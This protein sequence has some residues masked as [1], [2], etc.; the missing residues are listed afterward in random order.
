MKRALLVVL[1]LVSTSQVS[2]AQYGGNASASAMAGS[3]A[4]YRGDNR[5]PAAIERA[6]RQLT[7]AELRDDGTSHFIEASVL[8][9]VKAD[10]YVAVFG[11]VEEGKTV[12]EATTK[13]DA[14]IGKFKQSLKGLG[15][16]DGDIFVDFITQNR[17]YSYKI[18]PAGEGGG[19]TTI[20]EELVGFEIKK[21]VSIHF[22]DKLL[23]DA[24]V[25]AG[26]P[27][28]I[29]D[30]VKVDYVVKDIAAMKSRLQ[31]ETTRI[32][33]EKAQNH[34]AL[35]GIKLPEVSQ[36]VR[37]EPNIYFP[38]E[39][40]DSY[41]AAEAEN[42]T[43][44]R[45]EDRVVRARKNR[46]SYFNPLSGDGFDMVVNPVII[47]PVVQFTTYIKVRY[48]TPKPQPAREIRGFGGS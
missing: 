12:I 22:K 1:S 27:A 33:K 41:T 43:T 31:V 46:T 32:L 45:S 17:I 18:E 21:N 40:Y 19:R 20:R 14:S 36:V 29:Y 5:S 2:F 39:Q 13:M 9:N 44:Y 42:L 6:K 30:L 28:Q 15:L 3:S 48:G 24:L 35:L 47:E 8:M 11:V 34:Q 37:D 23:L 10:E 25:L 16:K 26:A 4:V 38:I 7:P